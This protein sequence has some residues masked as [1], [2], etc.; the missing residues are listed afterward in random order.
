VG[1]LE[2]HPLLLPQERDIG[3]EF[4]LAILIVEESPNK[5]GDSS[6]SKENLP[7]PETLQG[8]KARQGTLSRKTV[9]DF[10]P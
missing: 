7:T 9:R 2:R 10:P 8:G 1:I 5:L 4:L 6:T 3:L